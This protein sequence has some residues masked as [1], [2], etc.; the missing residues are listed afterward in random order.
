[1][2]TETLASN[3]RAGG[4]L[5]QKVTEAASRQ[6]D[7]RGR[8][9][10]TAIASAVHEALPEIAARAELGIERVWLHRSFETG[11]VSE[12]AVAY[13]REHGVQVIA[14]GCPCMF[15]RTADPGHRPMR[16]ILSLTRELPKEA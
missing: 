2:P 6:L 13:G 15:G 12:K 11:G 1:L 4:P 14:G 3:A 10:T 9:I 7:V 16:G 8:T 5:T